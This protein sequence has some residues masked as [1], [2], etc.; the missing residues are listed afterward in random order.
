MT[1][2][3]RRGA[4]RA[5]DYTLTVTRAPRLRLGF[6]STSRSGAV[7]DPALR[8]SDR[9]STCHQPPRNGAPPTRSSVAHDRS[10]GELLRPTL[11][12]VAPRT[13]LRDGLEPVPRGRTRALLVLGH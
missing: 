13:E 7:P 1:I 2:R 6:A 3:W 5:A 11:A 9:P 4:S 8:P 12:A 10:P